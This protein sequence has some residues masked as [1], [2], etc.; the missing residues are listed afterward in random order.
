[1]KGYNIKSGVLFGLVVVQQKLATKPAVRERGRLERERKRGG[2]IGKWRFLD[3][4]DERDGGQ[5]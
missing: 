4:T 5:E 3:S 2:G 1:M